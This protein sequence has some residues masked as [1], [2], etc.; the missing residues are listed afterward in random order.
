MN[1]EQGTRQPEEWQRSPFGVARWDTQHGSEDDK[2]GGFF[3][4]VW[5]ALTQALIAP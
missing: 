1:S 3:L 4:L 5:E 2:S